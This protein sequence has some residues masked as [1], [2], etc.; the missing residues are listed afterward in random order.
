MIDAEQHGLLFG[1]K[2]RPEYGIFLGPRAEIL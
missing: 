2:T 1:R